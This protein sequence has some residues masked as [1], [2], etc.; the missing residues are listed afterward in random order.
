MVIVI[1]RKNTGQNLD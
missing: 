1:F